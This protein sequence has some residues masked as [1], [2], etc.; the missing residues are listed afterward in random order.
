MN[1]SAIHSAVVEVR[2]AD[3]P[4]DGKKQ[5]TIKT[6]AGDIYGMKPEML[7]LFQR[8]RRYRIDYTERDFKGKTYRT[9]VKTE[10]D[11]RSDDRTASAPGQRSPDPTSNASTPSEFEFVTRL[12]SAYVQ[13]CGVG[14]TIEELAERGRML[15]EVYGRIFG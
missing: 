15:R 5:A 12:L 6:P 2:Y 3:P 1:A 7:G 8:G 11:E 13:C 9:I 4:R 14:R 10:P